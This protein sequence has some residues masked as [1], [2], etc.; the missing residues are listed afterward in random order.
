MFLHMLGRS[1]LE[2]RKSQ[3]D[4]SV[5]GRKINIRRMLL[6]QT[7]MR[8]SPYVAMSLNQWRLCLAMALLINSMPETNIRPVSANRAAPA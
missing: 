1:A 2:G 4:V 5:S 6:M 3:V 8:F 7:L